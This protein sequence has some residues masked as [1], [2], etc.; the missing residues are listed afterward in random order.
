MGSLKDVDILK[1]TACV[2]QG[3]EFKVN[4]AQPAAVNASSKL[5]LSVMGEERMELCKCLQ[6]QMMFSY[7]FCI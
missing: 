2:K 5:Y 3:W 6:M 1:N 4:T 7:I